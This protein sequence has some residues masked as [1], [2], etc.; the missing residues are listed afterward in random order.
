MKL[1]QIYSVKT[2]KNVKVLISHPEGQKIIC[3]RRFKRYVCDSASLDVR[4]HVFIYDTFTSIFKIMHLPQGK[5]D[6]SNN[7]DYQRYD[8]R[9]AIFFAGKTFYLQ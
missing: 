5:S 3:N 8:S 1:N 7:C 6:D 9:R 4:I 2:L